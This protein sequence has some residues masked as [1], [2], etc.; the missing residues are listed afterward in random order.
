MTALSAHNVVYDVPTGSHIAVCGF[1]VSDIYDV[2]KEESFAML[3][4]EVLHES[5]GGEGA[6]QIGD[7]LC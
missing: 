6:T 1:A 3:T 7:I 5:V 2:V 4:T